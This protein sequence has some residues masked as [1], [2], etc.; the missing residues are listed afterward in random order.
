MMTEDF[1]LTLFDRLNV[2]KD[3]IEHY[4]ENNFFISFSG[5]KDSTVLHHLV[6]MAMP[7]N[8]IPRV[9]ANTGI[10]YNKIV[11]FVESLA[12]EDERFQ[13]IKPQ[14]NIRKTLE[15]HGYPFKSKE[16][17][18]YLET[19]QNNKDVCDEYFAKVKENPKLLED[20]DF[21]HN[22]PRN[23]KYVLKQFYGLRERERTVYKYSHCP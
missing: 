5:G 7:G 3:T 17:S 23:A 14:A 22:L 8:K 19:Y 21:V 4:G 9:F 6:D 12:A 13:I 16:Y 18:H 20:Y 2:I 10:E 1:E 11:S 15:N